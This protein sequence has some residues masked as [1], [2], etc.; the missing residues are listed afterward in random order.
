MTTEATEAKTTIERGQRW[1]HK[2][3][4]WRFVRITSVS[5]GEHWR[6]GIARFYVI[7]N[8]SRRTQ[9]IKETTLRREYELVS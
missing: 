9:A 2:R 4:A 1:R 5:T 3:E 6:D 8:T 7:R